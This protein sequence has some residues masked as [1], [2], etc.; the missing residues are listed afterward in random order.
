MPILPSD[1]T[2]WCYP[3]SYRNWS[4]T[5]KSDRQ[6]GYAKIHQPSPLPLTLAQIVWLLAILTHRPLV[7]FLLKQSTLEKASYVTIQ[8]MSNIKMEH[9]NE[10][11]HG[12][13]NK[14]Y[15]FCFFYNHQMLWPWNIRSNCIRNPIN[16]SNNRYGSYGV[17]V[18]HN[19]N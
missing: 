12:F 13:I 11:S 18:V 14:V 15:L 7:S 10:I 17:G 16:T 2:V 1:I 4:D 9:A 5:Q 19:F 8:K 3:S 6:L